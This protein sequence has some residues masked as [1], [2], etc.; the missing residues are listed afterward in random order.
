MLVVLVRVPD[1]GVDDQDAV[2]AA[3]RHFE[4]MPNATAYINSGTTAI[5][6]LKKACKS[7]TQAQMWAV[8]NYLLRYGFDDILEHLCSQ[9]VLEVAK[10]HACARTWVRKQVRNGLAEFLRV[11]SDD[12]LPA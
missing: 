6:A 7:H 9:Q 11:V 2:D 3:R 1:L 5:K 12:L 10:H 8:T 4:N